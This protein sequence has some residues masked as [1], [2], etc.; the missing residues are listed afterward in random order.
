MPPVSREEDAA[1]HAPVLDRMLELIIRGQSDRS[2]DRTLPPAWLLT[3]TLALGRAAEEEV[4]EGRM[5]AEAA[6]AAVHHSYLRLLGIDA[7][8]VPGG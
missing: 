8:A 7:G 1:R 6:S 4:Q 2:L 5:T 3:A